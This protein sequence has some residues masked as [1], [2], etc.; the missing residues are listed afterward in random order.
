VFSTQSEKGSLNLLK[1]RL[2]KIWNG[3]EETVTETVTEQQEG[4]DTEPED[5]SLVYVL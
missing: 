5:K 2:T 1:G 4:S 3:S